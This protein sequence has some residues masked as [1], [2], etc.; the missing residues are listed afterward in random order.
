MYLILCMCAGALRGQ[1]GHMV[2][3]GFSYRDTGG[4]EPHDGVLGVELRSSVT[5]A[6]LSHLSSSLFYPFYLLPVSMGKEGN[7]GK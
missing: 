5:D 4:G 2:L 6:M 7:T 1:R 3:W